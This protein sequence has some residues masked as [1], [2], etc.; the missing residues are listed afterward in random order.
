MQLRRTDGV[1]CGW[2]LELE[3]NM[4]IIISFVLATAVLAG[5]AAF[6]QSATHDNSGA[7][8]SG[9]PGNKSGPAVMPPGKNPS[10]HANNSGQDASKVP[11]LPG[12]K[13]GPPQQP[14]QH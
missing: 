2:G 1:A 4:R 8:V 9:E 12:G 11:G 3:E 13:A 5:P 10:D 14:S 6:A 7:G